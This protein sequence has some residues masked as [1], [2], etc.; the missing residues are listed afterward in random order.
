MDLLPA[1]QVGPGKQDFIHTVTGGQANTAS[2]A[3]VA[4]PGYGSGSSFLFKASW[5][6]GGVATQGGVVGLNWGQG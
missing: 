5:P 1:L 6:T 4:V 2:P 3:F